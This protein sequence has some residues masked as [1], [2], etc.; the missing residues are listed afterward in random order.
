MAGAREMIYFK[1]VK[2]KKT[3]NILLA[4]I[5]ILT[6]VNGCAAIESIF[7]AGFWAGLVA[8]IVVI[9]VIW[10]IIAIIKAIAK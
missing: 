6:L 3:G 7:E 10:A 9:L 5:L 1:P 2:M 8:A 4:S